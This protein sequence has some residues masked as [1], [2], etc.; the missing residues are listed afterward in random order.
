VGLIGMLK[1]LLADTPRPVHGRDRVSVAE[2]R[3]E[4]LETLPQTEELD[5]VWPDERLLTVPVAP[6]W[7]PE[8]NRA[9]V[10]HKSDGRYFLRRDA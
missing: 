3:R 8:P 5:P 7:E 2:A 6:P 4:W 10:I 1:R 9:I